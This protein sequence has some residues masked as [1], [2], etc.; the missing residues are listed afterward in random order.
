MRIL[1]RRASALALTAAATGL[2]LTAPTSTPAPRAVVAQ[3]APD[4]AVEV[5]G[6]LDHTR[7]RLGTL[8]PIEIIERPPPAPSSPHAPG[9]A[10]G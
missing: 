5:E 8:A 3:R 4:G 10:S 7:L 1:L 9:R 6:S 2:G